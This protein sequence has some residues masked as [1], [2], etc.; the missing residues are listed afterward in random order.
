MCSNN[1]NKEKMIY[2]TLPGVHRRRFGFLVDN[3]SK[4]LTKEA[5]LYV[6]KI[7]T[8]EKSSIYCCSSNKR[9]EKCLIQ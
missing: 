2:I 5:H 8:I 6:L 9:L 1:L 4:K 3:L 7:N